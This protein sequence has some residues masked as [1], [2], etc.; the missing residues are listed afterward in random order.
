MRYRSKV[1]VLL[2]AV[3]LFSNG[4]LFLLL[5][6]NSTRALREQIGITA[7]SIAATTSALIDSDAHQKL[8]TRADEQAA[9][10][11]KVRSQLRTARDA[12]RR[13]PGVKV[14]FLYTLIPHPTDPS[15]VTFAVDP[16]ES[17]ADRSHLGDVYKPISGQSGINFPEYQV[18]PGF[19]ED[20]WGTWL[21][22]NAPLRNA[23][24]SVVGAV[25]ADLSAADVIQE[26]RRMMWTGLLSLS[27]TVVLTCIVGLALG[28]NVTRPLAV[29]RTSLSKIGDGDFETRVDVR[30]K[31]EFGDM[32]KTV[33][34]MA[35]GLQQREQLKSTLVQYVSS[36]VAEKIL[37]SGQAAKLS[38]DR[39]KIT[40]LFA[41]VRGFTTLS[42][43]LNPEEVVAVL[44]DYF[45]RM[46]DIILEHE[47]MLNK[48]LGDGLMALFGAPN[49][50][51]FQE[52]H[53]I[54]AALKM[55]EAMQ[56]LRADWKAKKGLDL[57]IGIGVNTGIAVVGNVGS[58]RRM[59]YT[60][61]GD[62][63]NLASRLESA[64]KEL[65]TEILVS[66]YT[67]VGARARFTFRPLESIRVKGRTDPVKVFSVEGTKEGLGSDTLLRT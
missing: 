10:Y 1:I 5:Y 48:F 42:E 13:V 30:S 44:D 32:A 16:E 65:G 63:V 64:N 43:N 41:D 25:G 28:R 23:Q 61:I 36:Q 4:I 29:L 9:D 21:T 24:G 50:D 34:K 3:V 8:K 11:E 20:Q 15:L 37:T 49:D 17:E 59:E 33:N 53:A 45:D 58:R 40:V 51:P 56:A 19:V 35:A 66:E 6:R 52:E 14:K 12:T 54:A 27:V 18:H 46:I 22:V 60:A 47:G 55:R 57:R 26:F 2:L 67:Y 7:I 39:R 31:D 38:G 62:T